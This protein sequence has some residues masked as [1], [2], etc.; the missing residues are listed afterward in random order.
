MD[1]TLLGTPIQAGEGVDKVLV[2]N[3]RELEKMISRLLLLPS[4]PAL[5]LLRNAFAIPK[6]L[7]IL[8]TAPCS[9][10]SELAAYDQSLK[11]AL[12]TILNIELSPSACTQ[13]GLP[14]RWG[15]IGIRFAHQL[16]PSAFLASAA[17]VANLLP[18][19][20][21][22]RV[23]AVED[24]AVTRAESAWSKLGGCTKPLHPVVEV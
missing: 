3:I 16:A 6:L 8:R 7:Y 11:S 5:F 21:P 23:L 12:S 20:L 10:S 14:L 4:H 13:A 1:A 22:S 18:H 2:S 17:G 15:G 19:I 24:K 9:D